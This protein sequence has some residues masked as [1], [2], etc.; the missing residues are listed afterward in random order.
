MRGGM[1][2][3]FDIFLLKMFKLLVIYD[4]YRYN[5]HSHYQRKRFSTHGRNAKDEM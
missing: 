1:A 4:T 3:K 5:L 2:S